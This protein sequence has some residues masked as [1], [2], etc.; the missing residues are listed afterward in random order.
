MKDKNESDFVEE[1]EFDTRTIELDILG[2]LLQ[3][4]TKYYLNA[5]D[6]EVTAMVEYRKRLKAIYK[7]IY[8]FVDKDNDIK[9]EIESS[10]SSADR[11]LANHTNHNQNLR[12]ALEHLEDA[13]EKINL[14]RKEANLAMPTKNKVDPEKAG[15]SELD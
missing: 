8:Y 11:L 4:K 9:T 7:H 2:D 13:D 6:L 3:S 14:L 15:V 10:F 1:S 5:L 12:R